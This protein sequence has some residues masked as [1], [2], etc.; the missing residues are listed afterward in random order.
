M[1]ILLLSL[2]SLKFT[3]L[4]FCG[5]PGKGLHFVIASSFPLRLYSKCD[6]ERNLGGFFCLVLKHLI[7]LADLKTYLENYS[8]L[9]INNNCM[10]AYLVAQ[11]DLFLEKVSALFLLHFRFRV[12]PS[13]ETS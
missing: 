5:M 6:Q 8:N 1:L 7:L 10:Q 11:Q 13:F 2:P 9:K 4:Q 3:I 12:S